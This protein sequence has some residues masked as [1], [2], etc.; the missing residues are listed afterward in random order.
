MLLVGYARA[1]SSQPAE[2]QLWMNAE[3]ARG[4]HTLAAPIFTDFERLLAFCEH[5]HQDGNTV[6]GVMVRDLTR[7]CRG[8][9]REMSDYCN[10]LRRAGIRWL[11]TSARAYDLRSGTEQGRLSA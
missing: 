10:R 8:D 3:V 6:D 9:A 7:L 4:N 1:S 2:Q 5:A 11:I